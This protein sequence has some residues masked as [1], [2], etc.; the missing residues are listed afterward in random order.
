LNT[1]EIEDWR[2]FLKGLA[3]EKRNNRNLERLVFFLDAPDLDGFL[4]QAVVA[5]RLAMGF[6]GEPISLGIFKD[7]GPDYHFIAESMIGFSTLLCSEGGEGITI[8]VDWFDQ[9]GNAPVMNPDETWSKRGFRGADLVLLPHMLNL[10]MALNIGLAEGGPVAR[11]SDEVLAEGLELLEKRGADSRRWFATIAS[12]GAAESA[13]LSAHVADDLGGQLVDVSSLALRHQMAVVAQARFHLG[14]DVL[15]TTMASALAVP[16]CAVGVKNLARRVWRPLDHV[17]NHGSKDHL[18][19]AAT[20]LFKRA[21]PTVK[22]GDKAPPGW[23]SIPLNWPKR[24]TPLVEIG[25]SD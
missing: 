3:E 1:E 13:A 20:A 24:K 9:G 23:T 18:I 12:L 11:L 2:G 10:D 14:G 17:V 21:G 8:P 7:R 22:V 5:S 16:C 25:V 19:A 4:H 6:A 15:A